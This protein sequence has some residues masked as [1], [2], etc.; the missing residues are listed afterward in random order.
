[1]F[2]TISPMDQHHRVFLLSPDSEAKGASVVGALSSTSGTQNP[3]VGSRTT[4]N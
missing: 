4:T 2:N 1:M 3:S